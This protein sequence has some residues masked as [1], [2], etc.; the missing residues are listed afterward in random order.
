VTTEELKTVQRL[1]LGA[2]RIV[3]DEI[4]TREKEQPPAAQAPA[5]EQCQDNKEDLTKPRE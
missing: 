4:A 5:P 1:L 2:K 3:D